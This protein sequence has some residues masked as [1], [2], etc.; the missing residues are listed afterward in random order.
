MITDYSVLMSLYV[1]EKPEYLIESLESMLQQTILPKQIVIVLDGEITSELQ[2][3]INKYKLSNPNLF[4]IVPLEQNIGLGLALNKG[5]E[6]CEFELIARMDT[7]DISYPERCELQLAEFNNHPELDIV[8]TLT[9]EFFESP[10]KI[11]SIRIVPENHEEILK[12]SRRRSPFNHPTVMYRK[13]SIQ[14]VGGYRDILRKE[15]LDLFARMLENGCKA[16]NIQKELLY[17]RSNKDNYK[18]RKSW[19]N[20]SNYIKVIYKFW[21]RGYSSLWDLLYVTFAQIG[22]YIA[23]T[24]LLKYISDSILRKKHNIT[25]VEKN[26]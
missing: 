6:H 26:D 22:M 10:D 25:G 5:L 18:R 3:V 24:W 21:R 11:Q 9:S 1:K 12:F 4:S 2:V 19:T 15:D 8:G 16:K 7:D 20:N 13:S 23:P 14:A 17:F